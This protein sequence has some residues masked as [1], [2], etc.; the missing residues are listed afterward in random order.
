ML[1]Y[2]KRE[3]KLA[4][5]HNIYICFWNCN[6]L[7]YLKGANEVN[8][9]YFQLAKGTVF[10]LEYAPILHVSYYAQIMLA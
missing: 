1:Q 8:R 2:N 5:S 3:V 6:Y 10:M 9:Q 4:T 7:G